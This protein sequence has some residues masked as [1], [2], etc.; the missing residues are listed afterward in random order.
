[1]VSRVTMG[2][3]IAR[4]RLYRATTCALIETKIQKIVELAT[5]SATTDK[6]VA[7]ANAN[8]PREFWIKISEPFGS[9][10]GSH[11]YIR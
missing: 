8:K 1:M 11:G 5:M 3:V 4:F 6:P 10:C 9:R 2:I 7:V